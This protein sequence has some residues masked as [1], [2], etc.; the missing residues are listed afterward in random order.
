MQQDTV[1]K[2]FEK[3]RQAF[4]AGDH[5]RVIS[6][7]DA[8]MRNLGPQAEVLNLKGLSLLAGGQPEAAVAHF[9]QAIKRQ[10]GS[11]GLHLNL[12]GAELAQAHHRQAKRHAEQAIRLA[13]ADPG[14]LYQA[15]RVCRDCG[16][17]ALALRIIERCLKR[18]EDFVPGWHFKGSL[19]LDLGDTAAATTAL[20]RAVQLQPGHARALSDLAAARGDGI[21]NQAMVAQLKA[22]ATARAPDAG[23]ALFALAHMYHRAGDVPAAWTLYQGAN[24]L[25]RSKSRFDAGRWQGAL[26]NVIRITAQSGLLPADDLSTGARM[27]FIVGMP[28]SGTT[29]LE[30]AL[31]A[32]P[33]VMAC[34]ELAAMAAVDASLHRRGVNPYAPAGTP[35]LAAALEAARHQ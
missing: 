33:A 1:R 6:L 13:P 25:A 34:G 16:D 20:E 32:H 23:S 19:L 31:A 26:Q 27:V 30:Q 14:V 12:A 2:Q 18:G 8:V 24:Q 35:G 22:A 15:A 11:A 17:Y 29:L 5:A 3:A 7:C 10:Q 28:R 4:A 9:T 21:D